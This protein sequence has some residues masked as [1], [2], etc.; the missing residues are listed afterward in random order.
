MLKISK[1]ADYA[2]IIMVCCA[3]HQNIDLSATEIAQYCHLRLPTVS[4]LLKKLNQAGLLLS[5]RGAQGGYQL[6]QPAADISIAMIVAAID[7]AIALT[8]CSQKRQGCELET[9]C[10]TRSSWLLINRT[11]VKALESVRLTDMSHL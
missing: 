4:K 11:V 7:G 2:T 8:E 1:M 3:K 10:V 5:H 6:A 9:H